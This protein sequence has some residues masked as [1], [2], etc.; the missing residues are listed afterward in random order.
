MLRGN[1]HANIRCILNEIIIIN[2]AQKV[3][4]ITIFVQ[5][6]RIKKFEEL[7]YLHILVTT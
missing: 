1:N 5:V 7:I 3:G 2:T 4:E 6:K